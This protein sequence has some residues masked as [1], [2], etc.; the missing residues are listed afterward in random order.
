MFDCLANNMPLE[1]NFINEFNNA[2]SYGV[3]HIEESIIE[4]PNNALGYN[5]LDYLKNKISYNLAADKRKALDKF[6]ELM[7]F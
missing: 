1:D 2:L 4:K 6:L 5:T 3:N 7:K